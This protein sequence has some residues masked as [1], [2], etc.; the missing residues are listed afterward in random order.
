MHFLKSHRPD[1]PFGGVVVDLEPAV[2]EEPGKARPAL[3]RLFHRI[4]RC[5]SSHHVRCGGGEPGMELVDQW[6]G[7]LLPDDKA[8]LGCA[9]PDCFSMRWI[10]AMR[11]KASCATG[12]SLP[13]SMKPR[14]R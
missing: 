12:A 1:G 13:A 2:I 4:A 7:S 9:P 8:F 3:E 10:S 5:R 6:T 11:C 14:R